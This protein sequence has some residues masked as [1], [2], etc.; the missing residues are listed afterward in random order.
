[1]QGAVGDLEGPWGWNKAERTPK[2]ER[3]KHQGWVGPTE[4][5]S[6]R[7]MGHATY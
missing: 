4:T 3:A 1:M 5:H 7:A 2:G 6:W